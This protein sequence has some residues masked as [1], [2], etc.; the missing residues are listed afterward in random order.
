MTSHRNALADEPSPYLQQHAANPVDWRPWNHA[1]LEEAKREDKP[2][3]LS[4]GYSAC[5][6]CHVMAHESFEDEATAQ[7]MNELYVN[8]KVDRE[9]R[10][11]LDKIYQTVHQVM[12]QRGGGWPLTVLLD[13]QD[14]MPFF[15]GTYFPS[16]P[17]HGLPSF[18]QLLQQAAHV[19]REQRDAIRQQSTSLAETLDRIEQGPPAHATAPAPEVMAT[20]RSELARAYDDR[21]GGFGGAPKF[22]Q[23]TLLA[24][25][26]GPGRD[27]GG[28]A[29]AMFTMRRM[30]LGGLSDQVGGG[31][32][33]Y[34]VDADWMIPHFEKMLYDNAQLLPLYA[35]AARR[36]GD[37]LFDDAATTTVS[38]L[39][40]EMRDPAGGFYSAL[41]ADSEG[42]E[43][44]F[45]VWSRDQL[46]TL[47]APDDFT[48][49]VT[50]FDLDGQPNFEGSWH[51]HRHDD[52]AADPEVIE[53]IRA[54]LFAAREPRVRPGRDDK[55][56]T[57]WN[58]L[59]VAGLARAGCLLA[60]SDWIDL[61][62]DTL[63][64]IR[65]ETWLDGR[66]HVAWK[67]G[68][69]Y[70]DGYLDDHAFVLDGALE[71]LQSRWRRADLDFAIAL[72]DALLD[73][74]EDPER[75]G[76]HFTAT[77]HEALI[78]RPKPFGDDAVP[79]GNG[80]AVRALGRLGHLLGEP[81]YLAAADRALKAAG[82]LLEQAASAH[83]GLLL[84]LA[85]H[86]AP[87]AQVV[88]RAKADAAGELGDLGPGTLRFVIPPSEDSLPGALGAMRA[89]GPFTAYL[90]R[91][92]SCSAP[93]SDVDVL[94]ATLND[95]VCG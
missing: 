30:A 26:L 94:R 49:A 5:H 14:R 78:T 6:W 19:F 95:E 10:P 21:R 18:T 1:A 75:G 42:H 40:R 38:W 63:D 80:V 2:I 27:E 51:L 15:A 85:E 66:L 46:E 52:G 91:G 73:R 9:E 11:D 20:A 76:F 35:E 89:D 53:R 77:D 24:F 3:L 37:P 93:I 67:D 39:V 86:H 17:R 34:S 92:T 33:R 60:R 25:L 7:V 36:S 16:E 29:M 61:A 87:P 83:C 62:A 54:T 58:G 74:F 65:R 45:Y 68:T 41:D 59:A 69:A 13:P 28:E 81:R 72:A 22:P 55:V 12:Q 64:F 8:I 56:L 71:L 44:K 50:I 57:S 43:G 4:I 31:F 90:C 88:I 48:A 79:A 23:P 47:L 82:A 70:L 32:C 84:A